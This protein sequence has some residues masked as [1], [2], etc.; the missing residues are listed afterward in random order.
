MEQLSGHGEVTIEKTG[1]V[2]GVFPYTLAIYQRPGSVL[3]HADL[4]VELGAVAM[5]AFQANE[6]LRLKVEDGRSIAFFVSRV[7]L[8]TGDLDVTATGPLA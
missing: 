7:Q 2:L 1:E 6:R 5:R 8:G 4:S 3:R